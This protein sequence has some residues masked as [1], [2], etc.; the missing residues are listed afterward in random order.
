MRN[1]DVYMYDALPRTIKNIIRK[2]EDDW[3]NW[4]DDQIVAW[5]YTELGKEYSMDPN[6]RYADESKKAQIE[7]DAENSRN[8][9]RR[10]SSRN[11][12]C[13]D[14]AKALE[15]TLND[16][17][18][19]WCRAIIDGSGPHE[20]NI[21]DVNG[22]RIKLDLQEDLVNIQSGRKLEHFG[23]TD[24]Y[25][26][27]NFGVLNQEQLDELLSSVNYTGIPYKNSDL[28]SYSEQLKDKD[29]PLDQKLEIALLATNAKYSEELSKMGYCE[30]VELFKKCIVDCIY[31]AEDSKTRNFR[32][33]SDISH[34]TAKRNGKFISCFSVKTSEG[35]N[36]YYINDG[37][38]LKYDLVD[39]KT[40]NELFGIVPDGQGEGAKNER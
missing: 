14:L 11:V 30:R 26:G 6:Y 4:T 32:Q 29:I 25:D 21:A 28:D 17:F 1:I 15:I 10:L 8:F 27:R 38:H 5:F 36:K 33:D 18:G 9:E 22:K 3:Q 13:I 31:S 39:E 7:I 40:Y 23:Q 35:K 24:Y 16:V 34:R 37:T 19:I 12:T 2:R 20:Y